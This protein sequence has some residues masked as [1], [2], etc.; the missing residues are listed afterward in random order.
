ESF[1]KTMTI[2]GGGAI[3]VELSQALNRLGVKVTLVEKSERILPKDEEELVLMVQQRLIDEGVMIHTS[4][5]AVK[6]EQNGGN[7]TLHIDKDGKEMKVE[8]EGLLV[9]LGRKANVE[10]YGLD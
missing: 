8:G 2:L 10:G 1:P 6:A 3:G 9:A 5:T 7:I 4:A